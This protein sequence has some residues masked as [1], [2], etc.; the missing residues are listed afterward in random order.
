MVASEGCA[1][2]K[3]LTRR[4]FGNGVTRADTIWHFD[5]VVP[6]MIASEATGARSAELDWRRYV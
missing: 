6:P 5:M 4:P 3:A 2:P 1:K